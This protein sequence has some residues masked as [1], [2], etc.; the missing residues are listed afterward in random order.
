[1]CALKWMWF[2]SIFLSIFIDFLLNRPTF[3]TEMP[4]TH[5]IS[6]LSYTHARQLPDFVFSTLEANR[7]DANV[8]LPLL[9]KSSDSERSNLPISFNQLWLCCISYDS[10][11]TGTVDMVLSCTENELGKYPIFIV[12]TRPRSLWTRNSLEVRLRKLAEA[13]FKSVPRERVYSVFAPDIIVSLFSQ[14]WSELAGV[15]I[16]NEPYYA[17]RL[18]SC[19]AVIPQ[20]ST[21]PPFGTCRLADTADTKTV[22]KLCRRFSEESEPF[23]LERVIYLRAAVRV[24]SGNFDIIHRTVVYSLA[25]LTAWTVVSAV[26][27]HRETLQKGRDVSIV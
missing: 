7:I 13:L 14:Q 15:G 25:G 1:M 6:I 10:S 17:A 27:I 23:V 16:N 3:L 4:S 2:R 24:H 18:L 26:M 8:I 19:T 20:P 22:A 9:R 11:I 12:P 5:E 21:L